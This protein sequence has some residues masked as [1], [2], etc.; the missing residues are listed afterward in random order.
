MTALIFLGSYLF[1]SVSTAYWVT[2]L[3]L[4]GDLRQMGSGNLGAMNTLR[5]AGPTPALLV[6]LTDVAKGVL[7]VWVAKRFTGQLSVALGAA[8]FLVLGH[9]F[10]IFLRFHGGKGLANLVGILAYLSPLCLLSEGIIGLVFLILF[11]H[12]TPACLAMLAAFPILFPRF[13]PGLPSV[14]FAVGIILV[15]FVKHI[16]DIPLWL[17]S[18]K[19]GKPGCLN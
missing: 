16:K 17:A 12:D 1:G 10:P 5:N 3:F 13:V 18:R 4:G 19:N 15:V 14:F 11:R 9:N 2:R 6:F 8:F 7:T